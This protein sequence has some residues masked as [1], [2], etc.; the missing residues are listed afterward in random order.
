[1]TA[2]VTADNK[3]RLCIR[4]AKTGQ[5]YLVKEA[6]GGWWIMAVP[7]VNP[8]RPVSRNRR[9]WAGSK[10]SLNEHLRALRDHGLRIRE[11][12]N[13]KQPVPACRF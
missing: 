10:R 13:A 9:E 4:G 12:E 3:R 8:Q 11:S 5:K 1:M 6:D 7:K 2:I